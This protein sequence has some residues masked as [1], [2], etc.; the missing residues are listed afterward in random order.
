LTSANEDEIIRIY[1]HL[2]LRLSKSKE[3]NPI[4]KALLKFCTTKNL[5]IK[6]N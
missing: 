2:F 5:S 3:M 4:S 1:Q 6:L